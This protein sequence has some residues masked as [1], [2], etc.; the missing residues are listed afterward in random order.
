M[1]SGKSYRISI[2]GVAPGG[3]RTNS[4]WEAQTGLSE[5][6]KKKDYKVGLGKGTDLGRVKGR[7]DEYDQNILYTCMKVWKNY[8]F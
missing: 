6:I 4:I 7:R 3:P 2:K 5:L 8:V 1:A